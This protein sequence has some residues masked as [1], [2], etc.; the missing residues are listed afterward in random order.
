MWWKSWKAKGW[1]EGEEERS[2]DEKIE[3]EEKERAKNEKKRI[4]KRLV[5]LTQMIGIERIVSLR[6]VSE[7][8]VMKEEKA[9][10]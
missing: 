5:S 1:D 7:K 3:E 6:D 10:L 2:E 4:E 9:I 8:M